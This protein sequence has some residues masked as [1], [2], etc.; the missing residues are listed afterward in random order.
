MPPITKCQVV[1]AHYG[2]QEEKLSSTRDKNT[3]HSKLSLLD[4]LFLA[5][6]LKKK[7]SFSPLR[8]TALSFTALLILSSRAIFSQRKWSDLFLCLFSW[9]TSG[10]HKNNCFLQ[11]NLASKIWCLQRGC[12]YFLFCTAFKIPFRLLNCP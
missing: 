1:K 8:I 3:I 9:K 2:F 11:T 7:N 4:F 10:V 6:I 12:I 5:F